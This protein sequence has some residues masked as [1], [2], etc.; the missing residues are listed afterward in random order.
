MDFPRNALY[1]SYAMRAVFTFRRLSISNVPP[2]RGDAHGAGV[3]VFKTILA[4]GYGAGTRLREPPVWVAVDGF[5]PRQ[6]EA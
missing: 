6:A 1:N 2:I 3:A 4:I 5:R